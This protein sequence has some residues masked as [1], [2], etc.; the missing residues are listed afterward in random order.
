MKRRAPLAEGQIWRPVNGPDRR[1]VALYSA[2]TAPLLIAG[3]IVHDRLA[4][5]PWHLRDR[6]LYEARGRRRECCRVTFR[7]WIAAQGARPTGRGRRATL[8]LEK[9]ARA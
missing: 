4:A 7:R 6:V 8:R 3:R 9:S 5:T 1:I 2:Q